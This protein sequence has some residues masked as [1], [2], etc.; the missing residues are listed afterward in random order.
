MAEMASGCDACISVKDGN[1]LLRQWKSQLLGS[2]SSGEN[3]S[4][5]NGELC[6]TTINRMKKKKSRLPY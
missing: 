3:G 6:I 4:N 1:E 2:S 5:G